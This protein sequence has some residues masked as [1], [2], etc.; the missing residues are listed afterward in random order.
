MGDFNCSDSSGFIASKNAENAS[1]ASELSRKNMQI[2]GKRANY[3]ELKVW[4]S[5][6]KDAES[7]KTKQLSLQEQRNL[8]DT[9][10]TLKAKI[11]NIESKDQIIPQLKFD[12]EV[13]GAKLEKNA[14]DMKQ[15]QIQCTGEQYNNIF[16]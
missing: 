1:L 9:I 6:L 14:S 5:L 3:P 12:K 11:A 10:I 2:Q 4:D 16:K 8:D 7:K 15:M 13:I